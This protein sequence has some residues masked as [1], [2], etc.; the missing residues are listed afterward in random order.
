VPAPHARSWIRKISHPTEGFG[1]AV[2][3]GGLTAGMNGFPREQ[4]R[5][6]LPARPRDTALHTAPARR[7]ARSLLLE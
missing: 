3:F 2:S 6:P 1:N 5:F 7:V 4:V